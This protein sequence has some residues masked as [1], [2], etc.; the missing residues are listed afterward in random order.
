MFSCIGLKEMSEDT[1]QRVL[2][3]CNMLQALNMAFNFA[4]YCCV[5]SQ[6]R[7][8]FAKLVDKLFRCTPCGAH[9]TLAEISLRDQYGVN[10][11]E[12]RSMIVDESAV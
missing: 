8:T 7:R 3:V 12:T 1:L 10:R 4:L 11:R 5:N 9:F 6:F 2:L